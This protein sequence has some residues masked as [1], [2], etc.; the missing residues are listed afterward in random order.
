MPILVFLV[1]PNQKQLGSKVR[2][3]NHL[4]KIKFQELVMNKQDKGFQAYTG[5]LLDIYRIVTF[6]FKNP[7]SYTKFKQIKN[8]ALNSGA[9]SLIETGT[10]LGVT[11]KRCA[12][13]FKNIYTVEL[14]EQLAEQAS[15]YLANNKNIEVIQ[16]DAVKA[17]PMILAKPNVEDVLIFLDAHFSAG[18]TSCGDNPE[19]ALEEMEILARY[20]NKIKCIIIDDF[21]CFG[22]DAGFPKKSSL[23]KSIEDNFADFD[24]MIHLDQVIVQSK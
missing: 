1:H 14:N 22:N 24:I 11:T 23:L 5:H 2:V 15:K 17:L 10:Y 19:P 3:A 4:F 7:H 9:K 18:V 12:S 20:K 16:G 21:R 6:Q 8:F 13:L